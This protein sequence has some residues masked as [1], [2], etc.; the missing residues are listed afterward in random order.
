MLT[1]TPMSGKSEG[2]IYYSP[3]YIWHA[4]VVFFAKSWR[5]GGA[6]R[7]FSQKQPPTPIMRTDVG[8]GELITNINNLGLGCSSAH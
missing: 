5:E 2:Y 4:Q 8:G 1:Q 7:C 3:G 6:H